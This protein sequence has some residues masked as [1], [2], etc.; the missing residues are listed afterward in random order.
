MVEW[1][2]TLIFI[3]FTA[4]LNCAE[5]GQ[6]S[7]LLSTISVP[8]FFTYTENMAY[9]FRK[10]AGMSHG[11]IL[12]RRSKDLEDTQLPACLEAIDKNAALWTTQGLPEVRC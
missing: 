11:T 7:I 3:S 8:L 10:E 2:T 4:Y 12:E 5:V 6:Q 9:R 1:N